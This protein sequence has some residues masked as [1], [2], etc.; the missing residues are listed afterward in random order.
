MPDSAVAEL[1][2]PPA[3]G[4]P[5][6]TTKVKSGLPTTKQRTW[7][8]KR[9][10]SQESHRRRP[11]GQK[12]RRTGEHKSVGRRDSPRTSSLQIRSML[13]ILARTI[14]FL[15]TAGRYQHQQGLR[16]CVY[17]RRCRPSERI[18]Q[19]RWKWILRAP[20]VLGLNPPPAVGISCH[21]RGGNRRSTISQ[22]WDQ[23]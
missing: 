6:V 5:V 14:G 4:S 9:Q 11:V 18:G 22:K 23:N 19:R 21:I 3:A 10:L 15:V 20:S 1:Q 7:N 13:A 12:A 16:S 17:R 8:A 2:P